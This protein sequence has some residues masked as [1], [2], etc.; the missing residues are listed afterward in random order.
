MVN[1]PTLFIIAGPQSSGKTTILHH[2][3]K[4]SP[5]FLFIDETNQY[6]L[7]NKNHLG[8]AFVTREIE[9]QIVKADIKKIKEIDRSLKFIIIETGI[10]HCSYLENFMSKEEAEVY[11]NKYIQAH[12]RLHP[13]VLFIDTKPQI[14]WQRRKRK[15]VERI[16]KAGVTDSSKKREMLAKYKRNIE[17]LYPLW[18]KYYKKIPFEKYMIKN[19]YSSWAAC[20]EKI[21]SII[22]THIP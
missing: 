15:Y 7:L 1:K 8:G 9:E 21:K 20:K 22:Q 16:Y 4:K 3:K 14:S 6:S 12:A 2:L 5:R 17:N 10:M 19:S 11:F 13:I 18:I